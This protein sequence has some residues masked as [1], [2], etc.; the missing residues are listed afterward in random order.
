MRLT[1]RVGFR[2]SMD[3][4]LRIEEASDGNVSDYLRELVLEKMDQRDLIDDMHQMLKSMES[5][6]PRSGNGPATG[7]DTMT[8]AILLELL[9]LMRAV[10][11][12]E[13]RHEAQAEVQRNG[14]EPWSYEAQAERGSR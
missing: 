12:V 4:K 8:Q 7:A 10:T 1:E 5:R 6:Q 13:R 14:L 11:P 9:L 3:E 2:C